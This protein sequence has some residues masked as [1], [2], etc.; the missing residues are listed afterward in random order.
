[1]ST[2]SVREFNSA[3]PCIVL[4][5]LIKETPKYYIYLD[6]FHYLEPKQKRV[7][8]RTDT[9]WSKAH[10]EPCQSCPDHPASSYR[11]GH[12]D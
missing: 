5:E 7:K 2:R 6:R 12:N 10:I 8:R 9:D 11:D 3:G 1:M 4:G